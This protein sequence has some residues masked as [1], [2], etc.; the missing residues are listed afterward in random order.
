MSLRVT[1]VDEQTGDTETQTVPD[2]DYLVIVTGGCYLSYVNDFPT[3]GTVQLTIK[4]RSV[5]RPKPR[6]PLAE[7]S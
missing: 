3:T 5:W 1:V 4:G 2:N 7:E 6:P